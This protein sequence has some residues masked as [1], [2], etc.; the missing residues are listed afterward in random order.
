M[1]VGVVAK[2]TIVPERQAEF[3]LAFS[4]YQGTVRAQESGCVFFCLHKSRD[5]VGDYVVMEQ[6]IND[7]ALV[8]HR[9][10]AHYK[11]LPE[12]MGGFLAA[13]PEIQVYDSVK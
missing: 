1:T 3:E 8:E 12:R 11:A 4:R 2:L 9:N 10:T 6:Y 5:T 13:P 7:D